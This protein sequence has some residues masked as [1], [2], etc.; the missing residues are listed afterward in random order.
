MRLTDLHIK[1]FKSFAEKT[2]ISFDNN[3]T[4]VVG[5]N[6]CGKSY[7]VDAIRW[8]LGEQKTTS[9]RLE[10]MENII[11]NGTRKRKA[12]GLAEVSLTFENT[13]NN[14]P[15]EFTSVTVT[16]ILHRDGESEYRL[17]DVPCR[18][19]DI[20]NLFLD[21]G[22]SSDSYAII[23]LKM[24][25]EI[26]NDRDNSRRKLFEQAAG[27]SKYKQRKKETLQKLSAT[28]AD[29][30]RVEDLL[31]EIEGNLKSLEKQARKAER[32]KKLKAEYKECSLNLISIQL[33]DIKNAYHKLEK[34]IDDEKL[35]V[36]E[37]DG[38]IAKLNSF[39][40]KEKTTL[41]DK[42]K[43]LSQSQH[44]VNNLNNKINKLENSLNI[45]KQE[46]K[47]LEEK[48]LQLQK[49]EKEAGPK[50][51]SFEKDIENLTILK[52]QVDEE[53]AV[54]ETK[55]K[56][57]QEANTNEESEK[58]ELETQLKKVKSESAELQKEIVEFEKKSAVFEA[59]FQNLELNFKKT[60]VEEKEKRDK[61]QHLQTELNT[62]S[63]N[64]K[65]EENKLADIEKEV[66][67]HLQKKK[68][69]ADKKDG[70][71][72]KLSS[73]ERKWDARKNEYTLV[74]SL[75]DNM[76]G[77]PESIR[78]LK[79]GTE[80][81]QNIP[82][83]S[84]VI[85]SENKYRPAIEN[86]LEPYLNYFIVPDWE[87]ADKAVKTLNDSAKGR[88]NFFILSAFGNEKSNRAN[89]IEG[90]VR[91]IDV[92][93]ADQKFMPLLEYLFQKVYIAEEQAKS[94]LNLSEKGNILLDSEGRWIKGDKQLS[95]GSVGLFE[96]KRIGRAKSLEKL[97]KEIE[98]LEKQS[99]DLK[100]QIDGVNQKEQELER[101]DPA[102]S[103][104]KVSED[105]QSL[106]QQINIVHAKIDQI[107]AN[108]EENKSKNIAISDEIQQI[109]T[110]K[111]ALE[112]KIAVRKKTLKTLNES[113]QQ[114]EEKFQQKAEQLSANKQSFNDVNLSFHQKKNHQENLKKEILQKN[115]RIDE[116]IEENKHIRR[117]IVTG[118]EKISE[119]IKSVK[120][121]E[122]NVHNAHDEKKLLEKTLTADENTFFEAKAKLQEKEKSLREKQNAQRQNEELLKELNEKITDFKIK[123]SG[124]R[125]RLK[126]E[127]NTDIND[128]INE[129]SDKSL[130]ESEAIEKTQKLKHRIETFGEVNPMAI[131]AYEEMKSRYDF[132]IEQRKDLTD[133]KTSLVTTINKIEDTAKSR[134]LEA[135]VK[136]RENFQMVFRG[137]FTEEDQ[138]DL[139]LVNPD[140]PLESGI[141]IFAQ[142]KGK[143][144][145]VIDQLSGGEKAL[146]A[147]S[148]LFS[149]YLLKPAP[150]CILDEVDAPLDDANIEKFNKTIRSFSE[151][152]QFILVTHNKL[153][154]SSVDVI[155]G[156]TMAEQGV[157]K[158]VPVNFSELKA[159]S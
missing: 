134:F 21:T 146:T 54:L 35:K 74:K 47:F 140:N 151:K 136:V 139:S 82:L 135:F 137:L 125:E 58:T 92:I 113:Q 78:Y 57:L 97:K 63:A 120:V 147:L 44:S 36:S 89:E 103:L 145:Q 138:C 153:T 38:E 128:L 40:E 8:V 24:I 127:F 124:L 126:I 149:L 15:T 14:L 100:G 106:Q 80:F 72:E 16:R 141:Q 61:I 70:L 19:K 111:Q 52:V 104:I 86:F 49:Q 4:G 68:D 108:I 142:P 94:T 116:I 121:T 56:Q 55:V 157:S 20:T 23:E 154:M 13:K 122:E 132:I 155:Y 10:K 85:Y 150:F 91:A 93:E 158:V 3:I 65:N 64:K 46:I 95:G 60:D 28:D 79:K 102:K 51:Q 76:E 7:I 22:I 144:P 33:D 87:T 99:W 77:F 66:E 84:D 110:E 34:Q 83:L 32:F 129:E 59:R 50:R 130:S 143:R 148:L 12:S 30:E 1:G 119:L 71:K 37:L 96:G 115:I 42:E 114:F 43:E 29:L 18:L 41:L 131:E 53:V 156:V 81:M 152:S 48:L 107:N 109:K 88:A 118:E 75:V 17:N 90:T 123:L 26:L 159:A 27:I 2:H 105:I 9:L 6:G 73:T 31:F 62:F 112:E 5:P 11:F 69:L 45:Q 117:E 67:N 25:D 39:I 98:N 133:A 101:I